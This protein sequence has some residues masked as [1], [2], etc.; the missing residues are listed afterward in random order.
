VKEETA[1]GKADQ[2]IK[3][4][5]TSSP[6]TNSSSPHRPHRRFAG[7]CM[8]SG[9]CRT[10]KLATGNQRKKFRR[11][12]RSGRLAGWIDK[13]EGNR[14]PHVFQRRHARVQTGVGAGIRRRA[15]SESV[16]RDDD[17]DVEPESDGES[18]SILEV[19][20][21]ATESTAAAACAS[22]RR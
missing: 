13:T 15:K 12:S 16:R 2:Q 7:W 20:K 10:H 4:A 1:C 8:T 14:L 19:Q 9:R 6:A 18:R 22:S 5:R 11:I 21:R 3:L 17:S